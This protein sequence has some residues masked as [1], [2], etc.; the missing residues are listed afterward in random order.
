MAETFEEAITETATRLHLALE[1]GEF[2]G[3]N[4]VPER[5]T[6]GSRITWQHISGYLRGNVPEPIPEDL[7]GVAVAAG[8]RITKG[9]GTTGSLFLRHGE[10]NDV[11]DLRPWLGFLLVERMILNRYRIT[12]A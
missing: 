4:V 9:F 10:Y 5:I 1:G 3:P 8:L 7:M 12:V 2:L 6:E 11:A